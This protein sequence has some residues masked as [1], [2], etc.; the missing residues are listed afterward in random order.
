MTNIKLPTT[1]ENYFFLNAKTT[2]KKSQHNKKFAEPRLKKVSSR[3]PHLSSKKVLVL[4]IVDITFKG[5]S[6]I[7]NT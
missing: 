4:L 3:P 6:T 2:I 1:N 7:K 5:M